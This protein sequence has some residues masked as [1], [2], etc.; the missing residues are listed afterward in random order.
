MCAAQSRI[1]LLCWARWRS[2]EAR[3][4]FWHDRTRTAAIS[5]HTNAFKINE[6]V[7]V[8][9]AKL[10]SFGAFARLENGIEVFEKDFSL[11]EVYSA[12]EA[13]VTG[14]FGGVKQVSEVDG[15]IIGDGQMGLMAKRL[16]ELYRA[17]LDEECQ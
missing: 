15:R 14:T 8:E 2:P 6:D 5:A 9:V 16:R 7:E 3:R 12:D 17:K 1:H 10:V 11:M 13:F 4:R